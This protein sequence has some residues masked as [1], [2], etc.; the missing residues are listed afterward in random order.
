MRPSVITSCL[1]AACLPL[2]AGCGSSHSSAGQLEA[3]E[4]I[5]LLAEQELKYDSQAYVEVDLGE[6]RVTHALAG[7]EGQ[8]L[9]RFHLFGIVPEE[10]AA[11]LEQ[12]LPHFQNRL[13]DA[14]IQLVQ[15]TETEQF[16]D[17]GLAFFRAE[18]IAAVN[19]ILQDRLL[20]DVAFS[21]FSVEPG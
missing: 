14:V 17:P 19:R 7:G 4:L 3:S 5:E 15:K 1:L 11:K 20:K 8:I 6:F 16:G 12:T 2:L 18:V 10:R 21:D 9:V 13:R